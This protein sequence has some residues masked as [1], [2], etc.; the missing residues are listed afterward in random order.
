MKHQRIHFLTLYSFILLTFLTLQPFDPFGLS[1]RTKPSTF[2]L[3]AAQVDP[4]LKQAEEHLE[5]CGLS[6]AVWA[7]KAEYLTLVYFKGNII[8]GLISAENLC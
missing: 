6:C 3:F 4:Q 8:N 5:G 1:L 2:Y 7:Q